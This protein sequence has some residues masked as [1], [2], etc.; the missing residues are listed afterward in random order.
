ME[1]RLCYRK[2]KISWWINGRT[3]LNDWKAIWD[4]QI[5]LSDRMIYQTLSAHMNVINVEAIE[6]ASAW[7]KRRFGA[8]IVPNT[9]TPIAPATIPST[10][11]QQQLLS[12]SIDKIYE[13]AELCGVLNLAGRKLKEFPVGLLVKYDISDVVFADLSDNRFSELPSCI[14]ELSSLETLRVR[15]ASLRSLPTTVQFLESLAY[16]DLCGN[17]LTSLPIELFSIPL[18]V[19]L[20][21]GNRLESIPREIRQ[22]S[23]SLNELDVSCNRLKRIPADFALLK[24]LRVL[25]LR[26]NQLTQLPSE[27]SQLQLRVLDVSEN[28]LTELPFDFRFMFSLI[29]LNLDSNPLKS[30]LAKVCQKG[31]E[32]VFKW[33]HVHANLHASNIKQMSDIPF[34]GSET[35]NATLRR[36]KYE[37][38]SE[39]SLR[40]CDRRSRSSRFNTLCGSDSGYASTVDEHRH[41]YESS[42]TAGSLFGNNESHITRIN[43]DSNIRSNPTALQ[44]KRSAPL[45]MGT[46]IASS[47]KSGP[48]KEADLEA[49]ASRK[50]FDRNIIER[51]LLASKSTFISNSTSSSIAR[52]QAIVSPI[53][54]TTVC[55]NE[56]QLETNIALKATIVESVDFRDNLS[57]S[58][59][60]A[61]EC[62]MDVSNNNISEFDM[63][64]TIECGDKCCGTNHKLSTSR[65]DQ[66]SSELE[67]MKNNNLRGH[68]RRGMQVS[69]GEFTTKIL[70][71][72]IENNT[73]ET[74]LTCDTSSN[75][76]STSST[77]A[78][79][80]DVCSATTVTR[81]APVKVSLSS[82]VKEPNV[83]PIV[84]RPSQSSF[85]RA[86]SGIRK[87]SA[88]N[89]T[90]SQTG[91]TGSSS[92]SI[93]GTKLLKARD[94]I[95]IARNSLNNKTKKP[96]EPINRHQFTR[97][98]SVNNNTSSSNA[99]QVPAA[100][101]VE[102]MRKA[103]EQRL[104]TELPKDREQLAISL[105]D[106]IHLCNF[107][108]QIR[109][110]T[111]SSVLLRP[112][113]EASLSSPK[114]R[115]NIENFLNACRRLGIPEA[116]LCNSLDILERRNLQQL[117]RTVLALNK[118]H[119]A[120]NMTISR[121]S[122][123][124]QITNV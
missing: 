77:I 67:P 33:L 30:P 38:I 113:Q 11:S 102:A 111:I 70:P 121:H 83:T 75:I 82:T 90:L 101:V 74:S 97:I 124:R 64:T 53:T 89:R 17:Q 32:H 55:A 23:A 103:I 2:M 5:F 24:Y 34:N 78:G 56:P 118:L 50:L 19:L 120:Y 27:L 63:D 16:L 88:T 123:N 15:H 117:A 43:Y 22:L 66:F 39:A 4:L 26:D 108:N 72:V 14:C 96:C 79:S 52:P 85:T 71:P 99:G 98:A 115:R 68:D 112:S 40:R 46:I 110:K 3:D 91:N 6:T 80:R 86:A 35:I 9:R 94:S 1:M 21:S 84:V 44:H 100:G 47:C 7:R 37:N 87:P 65:H 60:N 122:D 69:V 57:K 104:N 20:L 93:D 76:S 12:R 49:K 105:A 48:I 119:A 61:I 13:D 54:S 25:N 109:P 42:T 116:S 51:S 29:N 31:I 73:P 45:S 114:C 59:L 28:E 92:L 95:G 106:G 8:T 81:S 62:I 41:S 36:G 58:E 18:Q 107:A 10:S